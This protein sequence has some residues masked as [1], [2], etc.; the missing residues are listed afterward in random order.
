MNMVDP[1]GMN[2]IGNL[3]GLGITLVG[4]GV[5]ILFAPVIGVVLTVAGVVLG[6]NAVACDLGGGFAC[7][8]F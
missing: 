4:I 1:S 5:G 8:I 7:G 3:L 6:I 2:L